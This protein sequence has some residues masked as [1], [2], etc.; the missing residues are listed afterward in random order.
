MSKESLE[1]A[2]ATGIESLPALPTGDAEK[3][4]EIR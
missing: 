3:D 1:V 2:A 4:K